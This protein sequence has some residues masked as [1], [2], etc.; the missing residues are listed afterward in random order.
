MDRCQSGDRRPAAWAGRYPVRLREPGGHRT[1][2][3]PVGRA[4]DA[5]REVALAVIAG[6]VDMAGRAGDPETA[7]AAMSRHIVIARERMRL[8]L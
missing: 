5:K 3:R 7:A 8:A 1:G 4:I 2:Q 6:T